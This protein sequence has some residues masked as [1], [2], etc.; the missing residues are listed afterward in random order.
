MIDYRKLFESGVHFGHQK[1]KW[2]PKM[3]PFIWG[4]KDG[5][6]LIDISKTAN[7]M[8]K[9]ANFLKDVACEGR[10]ILWVGAKPAA[11]SV[12]EPLAA[13]LNQP[14]ITNRWVGGTLTNFPQVKKS[15]T[16]Y[17][18]Y[19]DILSRADE[20]PY[21][22]KELNIIKKTID[23]LEHTIGGI[24]KLS[25]PVGALVVVD[26]KREAT[27]I[28]E[29]VKAGVPVVALVDTNCDPSGIDFVIPGNDDSAKSISVVMQY[30]AEFVREGKKLAKDK[31]I[32]ESTVEFVEISR[33]DII[34]NSLD[35]EE[36][37]NKK[38]AAKKAAKKVALPTEDLVEQVEAKKQEK[39]AKAAKVEAAASKTGDVVAKVVKP[40]SPR[41][42]P[43]AASKPASSRPVSK[44]ASRPTSS[45]RK[46]S[47]SR[48]TTKPK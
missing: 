25:W 31:K 32:E 39:A 35:D 37:E 13:E 10:Q 43:R 17:L 16:K 5:I 33:D 27:A 45:A 9:A 23:R 11:K 20:F 34:L 19:K 12:I 1:T 14:Y 42:A 36:E 41:P 6:H 4:H 21:T 22:K 46:P 3:K 26:V 7:A 24:V 48:G 28:K 30:L 15:V 29:A 18:H 47:A 40:S 44:P 8:E 2:C 38:K